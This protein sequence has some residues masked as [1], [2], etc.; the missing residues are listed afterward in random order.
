MKISLDDT[1]CGIATPQGEGGVGIIRVSGTRAIGVVAPMVK[2]RSGKGL[3]DFQSHKLYLSDLVSES[4]FHGNDSSSPYPGLLDQALVVVMKKPRSYT[5]Q[6]VVEIHSHGGPF[7]LQATCQ[8]LVRLGAR[9]ANPGEFTQRAFLNGR[10]DLVQAEAVLDTIQAT[11]ARSLRVAQD[12][13]RGSLSQAVDR[14]SDNLIRVLAHVEAG[15]DFVEEDIAFIG[16]DEVTVVCEETLEQLNRLIGSFEEGR[17]VREGVRTVIIGRPNVGKSSLLNV[18]LGSDRAIVSS[19]PGT[20]R[21]VIDESATVKGIRLHLLDTAGLRKT[22]D[23]LESE[24]IRRTQG[25][26]EKADVLLLVID[27]SQPLTT[28]DYDLL[29]QYRT[30]RLVVVLNKSDLPG[31]VDLGQVKAEITLPPSQASPYAEGKLLEPR[32]VE[33]STKTGKGIAD[34]AEAIRVVCLGRSLE[35]G[36]SVVVTRVRHRDALCKGRDSVARG[37]DAVKGMMPGECVALDIR[38]ALE[39]LGE[40]TGTV[41]TEDILDRVFRDFC[42]GK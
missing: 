38:C 23:V 5:G 12:L 32:I 30:R 39:A 27:R 35:T 28:E 41:S 20:T 21:D 36:E 34:L 17:I 22:I 26:V 31:R 10:L 25:A 33:I 14:L 2:T 24:G 37:L 29:K 15:I 16:R 40:I 6:D 13:L 7:V 9:L 4:A 8:E 1:I 19:I 3:Q 11:N 42:I 18:L